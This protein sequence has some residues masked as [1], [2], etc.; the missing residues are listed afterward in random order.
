LSRVFVL[1]PVCLIDRPSR[2]AFSELARQYVETHDPEI[3]K[4]LYRLS[5]ELEKMERLEKQ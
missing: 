4:E 2:V 1:A 3:I 5:R